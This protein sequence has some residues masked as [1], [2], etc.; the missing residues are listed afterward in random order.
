MVEND[1]EPLGGLPC[2]I[3]LAMEKVSHLG[4]IIFAE[5]NL[6]DELQLISDYFI[7]SC[8]CTLLIDERK[9]WQA[10]VDF[11]SESKGTVF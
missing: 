4:L 11:L 7:N 3:Y 1:C 10:A 6:S 5:N 9:S 2:A 8:G